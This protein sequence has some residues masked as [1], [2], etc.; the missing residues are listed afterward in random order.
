MTFEQK[1]EEGKGSSQVGVWSKSFPKKKKEGKWRCKFP[2]A[3]VY[4][5]CLEAHQKGCGWIIMSE[6]ERRILLRHRV[7]GGQIML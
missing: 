6:G 1:L 3:R 5:A 4:R 7:C 2:E